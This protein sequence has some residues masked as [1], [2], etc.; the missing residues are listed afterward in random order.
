MKNKYLRNIVIVCLCIIMCLFISF[1]VYTGNY[2]HADDEAYT[3]LKDSNS[4]KVLKIDDG[5]FFDGYGSDRAIIFYPGAKVEVESYSRI[6]YK[7]AENGIDCFLI[8]M[9]FKLAFFGV[10]KA[11]NIINNYKYDSYTLMGHSLGG[12]AATSYLN[13]DNKKV[14]SIIFLASYPNNKVSDDI[15]MLFIYGTDDLVLSND[16][17]SKSKE[18]WNTNYSEK[19]I[20]GGNHAYFGLYGEQDGDGKAKINY[21]EQQDIT[22]SHIIEFL[23][24]LQ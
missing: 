5:Y 3:Y 20:D 13:S 21:I 4:V 9:P 12:V 17:Y 15:S 11:N 24:D 18:Y 8:D 23:G 22:L 7:L 14:D 19:I 6:M 1:F 2:Y 10:N 16:S